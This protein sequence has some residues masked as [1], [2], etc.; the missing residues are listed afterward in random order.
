MFRRLLQFSYLSTIYHLIFL[1]SQGRFNFWSTGCIYSWTGRIVISDHWSV[2]PPFVHKCCENKVP[3][4][5]TCMVSIRKAVPVYAAAYNRK[6]RCVWNRSR[7]YKPSRRRIRK[8]LMLLLNTFND[9][10]LLYCLSRVT[11][12]RYLTRT[13][14]LCAQLRVCTNTNENRW[15]WAD[16]Y[17]ISTN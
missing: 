7:C 1:L 13:A 9:L 10:L 12:T 11:G 4:R 2:R 6:K 16:V 17:N 15:F 5:R 14:Q 3:S 8:R